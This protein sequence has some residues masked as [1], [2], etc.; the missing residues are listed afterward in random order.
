MDPIRKLPGGCEG[1]SGCS[2]AT[3]QRYRPEGVPGLS[4]RRR[5]VLGV[6]EKVT[7]RPGATV[8]DGVEVLGA[9]SPSRAGDFKACPLLYRYRTVDKLPEP[10][11]RDAL[12]GTVVH[13]VLEQLF[14]LPA[15]DRTPDRAAG[16][17]E[18]AYRLV[19]AEEPSAAVDEDGLTGWLE[20]CRTV[21]GRY[22]DLEDPRRLEPAEREA[23]VETLLDSKLLLRGVVDRIDVAPDGSVRIVDYKTGRSISESREGSALF[24]L[25]FYALVLW[26]SR[27]VVPSLLQLLYL[28]NGETLSYAPDEAD[29][30]ATERLLGALWEAIRAAHESGE[31]QAQR[32]AVCGWCSFQAHCPEFGG[33]VLPLPEVRPEH[34]AQ[35]GGAE[36]GEGVAEDPPLPLQDRDVVRDD[37]DGAAGGLG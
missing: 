26:R 8:V 23:Y 12:R 21:L 34:G 28:G 13:K 27:G 37:Q 4:V 29:L 9:L 19:L 17:I 1:G 36:A 31:F 5:S 20:S 10:P 30:V 11:S 2:C 16:M 33:T 25:R 22:F 7:E 15:P 14:D 18:D 24:Q 32:S 6:A 3:G 35:I